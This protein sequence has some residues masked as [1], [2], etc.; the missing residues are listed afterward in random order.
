MTQPDR[1]L[2][3]LPSLPPE[4]F[5]RV[6]A[7]LARLERSQ[8]EVSRKVDELT[9]FMNRHEDIA[10]ELKEQEK[11]IMANEKAIATYRGIGLALG[12]ILLILQILTYLKP[13][14]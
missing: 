2:P 8:T 9:R 13:F 11:R 10:K 7:V 1:D 3:S 12:G 5:S 14:A 6:E 4:V